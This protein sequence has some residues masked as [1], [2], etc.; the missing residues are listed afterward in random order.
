MDNAG[1]LQALELRAANLETSIRTIEADIGEIER[2]IL[3]GEASPRL[4]EYLRERNQTLNAH[5]RDLGQ[6]EVRIADLRG[7][8][9]ERTHE[10]RERDD[11]A[12]LEERLPAP[13]QERPWF[14]RPV[15][16]A[17]SMARES[18]Q[19]AGR[20]WFRREKQD[21]GRSS[22]EELRQRE[23]ER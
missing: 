6:T 5:Y 8:L 3:R 10:A 1:Q 21:D 20:D 17:S 22:E 7:R 11:D 16:P 23:R 2:A 12:R 9:A 13:E 19:E 15:E 14:R 4:V 18:A